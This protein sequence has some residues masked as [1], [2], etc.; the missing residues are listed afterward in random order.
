M[1]EV[2]GAE[3][4]SVDAFTGSRDV[5]DN[6]VLSKHGRSAGRVDGFYFADD[7]LQGLRVVHETVA[8]YIDMC[9]V[10]EYGKEAVMLSIEPFYSLEGLYVYDG[11]GEYLGVVRDVTRDGSSNDVEEL[12]VRKHVFSKEYVIPASA[13]KTAHD[14]IILEETY[15]N[16]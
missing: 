1:V 5:L 2:I 7:E 11:R 12:V 14:N 3:P 15:D 13:I 6:E 8:Y 9:F 4:D 16:E 10:K